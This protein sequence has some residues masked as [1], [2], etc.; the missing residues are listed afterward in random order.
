MTVGSSEYFWQQICSGAKSKAEELGVELRV[1]CSLNDAETETTASA[2]AN[3]GSIENLIGVAGQI[4]KEPLDAACARIPENVNLTLIEGIGVYGGVSEKRHNASVSLN[5]AHYAK[6]LLSHIPEKKLVVLS[7][8]SGNNVVLT[9][10]YEKS[11]GAQNIRPIYLDDAADAIDSL[12]KLEP[13]LD[14]FDAIVFNSGNFV[15][16]ECMEFLKG[17]TIYSSDLN[18]RVA[19]YIRSGQIKFNMSPDT[20]RFGRLVL[21]SALNGVSFEVPYIEND[22]SNIDTPEREKFYK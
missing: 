6:S 9:K 16:D 18:E 10:E 5:N 7:Y 20:F 1:V 22:R 15:R 11:R 8:S 13:I 12:R 2:I 17:R 19:G 14:G 21:L 3:C 4:N